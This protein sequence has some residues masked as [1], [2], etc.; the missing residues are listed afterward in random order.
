MNNNRIQINILHG[1]REGNA[2]L[3]GTLFDGPQKLDFS[4]SAKRM[5]L[6]PKEDAGELLSR[7]NGFFSAVSSDGRSGWMAVDRLRT[8]PLFYGTW[9]DTLFIS[10]NARWVREKVEEREMDPIARQEFL[11][12]GYV[13]GPDTLFSRVKQVQAGELVRFRADDDGSIVLEP[14]RYFRYLH[15]DY[16]R[17]DEASLR[18]RLDDMLLPTFRRMLE[19]VA[20]RT[21]VV[22]LSGGYDSRLIVLM[23][24]RMEYE[25]VVAFSYGRPGNQEAETSKQVAEQLGIRWEFV[26]Y[27]DE[28]WYQWYRS[29]EMQAY[30]EYADGLCSLPHIQDWPAVMALK[31]EGRI[32]EDSVFVPGHSADLPAG[33]RSKTFPD[34]YRGEN[35]PE[36]LV[37]AITR[38]HYSLFAYKEGDRSPFSARDRIPKVLGDPAQYP[39]A[40]SAFES[41]DITERQPKFIVNSLRV[42]EQWGYDWWIP[43]WDTEFMAYWQRIPP[44]RRLNQNL[45]IGYV[46]DL[47]KEMGV[48]VEEKVPPRPSFKK[49]PFVVGIKTALRITLR[50]LLLAHLYVNRLRKHDHLSLWGCFTNQWIAAIFNKQQQSINGAFALS[51]IILLDE[52]LNSATKNKR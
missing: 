27:S 14:Q 44:E 18:K 21:I 12:A 51:R 9:N 37:S 19:Y 29:P 26:P 52:E 43:F 33:S 32:P 2:F 16:L 1:K 20:G 7:T 34:L 47:A 36:T 42:Y 3:R 39:D 30:F 4:E 35:D 6:L 46:N 48:V 23:L 13:T 24:K 11:L 49:T 38:Y 8:M 5:A 15:H 22:P 45:Y 31:R 40:A 50:T 25:N 28:E 10:D 17:E 41:W